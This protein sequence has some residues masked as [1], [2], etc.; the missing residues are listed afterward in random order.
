[1]VD[2]ADYTYVQASWYPNYAM[3]LN[4]PRSQSEYFLGNSRRHSMELVAEFLSDK[5]VEDSQHRDILRYGPT[6]FLEY[7]D[8]TS[9]NYEYG[10]GY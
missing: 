10:Y 4:L 1:M 2:G 7:Y 9:R 6:H 5:E 8:N 3:H